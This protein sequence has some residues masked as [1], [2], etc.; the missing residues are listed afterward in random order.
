M[1]TLV[2]VTYNAAA[3]LERTLQSV[4]CQ[5]YRN[6]E[7]LII[8]GASTDGTVEIAHR[9]QHTLPAG[10]VVVLS[11]PDGGL[12]DAMNKG[13]RLAKGDYVC[14]LNA[15]DKLHSSQTLQAVAD[16]VAGSRVPVGVV[17][18][19]TDIV[20]DEGRFLR[21]RRLQPPHWL[22]WRSFRHG[23]L[24]CHQSFYVNRA[25]ACQY[26]LRYRYSADFDWCIRCMKD[27]EKRKMHN[28]FV[29]EPLCDYLAEGMTTQNHKASL[30]ERFRI[31]CKHYGT[32]S[33]VL[34]HLW[35]VLRGVLS[36]FPFSAK[37]PDVQNSSA[38]SQ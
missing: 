33:T 10:R 15:G 37:R 6:F 19:Y 24:V 12:Y 8:D 38:K 32:L 25:I 20:D 28:V 21:H 3:T 14:F 7:H 36:A 35:F 18:G 5:S 11:E 23:M 4:G 17:Y 30:R 16:A 29:R 34:M 1:I 27:A 2:T 22:T 13:L 9:Y 26:D 31:M